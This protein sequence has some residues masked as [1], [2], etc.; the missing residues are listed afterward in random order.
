MNWKYSSIGIR[1]LATSLKKTGR[2]EKVLER[3]QPATREALLKP[4]SAA[5]H[6]GEVIVDMTLAIQAVDGEAGVADV[7][8]QGIKYSLGPFLE[9]FLR[10]FITISGQKPENLFSRMDSTLQPVM[11]GLKTGWQAAGKKAGVI[12]IVHDD[13]MLPISRV[14]WASSLRYNFDLSSSLGTVVPRQVS[15]P[16]R[17][18]LFD[19]SW[20]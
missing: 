1:S 12:T 8:Y 3:C 10:V 14:A 15:G 9:P 11:R 4:S 13:V 20:K 19:A 2:T 17:E 5:W 16:S 6:D 18:F 7:F